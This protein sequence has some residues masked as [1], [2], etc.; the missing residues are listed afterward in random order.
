MDGN[1]DHELL[2]C[3][4]MGSAD[5]RVPFCLFGRHAGRNLMDGTELGIKRRVD[6]VLMILAQTLPISM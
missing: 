4:S 2:L 3:C 5:F 1:L 6:N